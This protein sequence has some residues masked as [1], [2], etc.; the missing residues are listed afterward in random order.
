VSGEESTCFAINSVDHTLSDRTV[1][2]TCR[3][4]RMLDGFEAALQDNTSSY[5]TP[6]SLMYCL[7]AGI[8]SLDQQVLERKHTVIE[9]VD[10]LTS[11]NSASL[12]STDLSMG[13]TVR[14]MWFRRSMWRAP[15]VNAAY[16]S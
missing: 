15:W 8:W 12:H 7:P 16:S 9:A 1:G 10:A 14:S 3:D 5:K 2:L 13:S 11:G 6:A 4:G